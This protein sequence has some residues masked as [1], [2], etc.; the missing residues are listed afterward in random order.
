[1]CVSIER[2]TLIHR[3][4]HA[5]GELI[6]EALIAV[7]RRNRGREV[8]VDVRQRAGGHRHLPDVVLERRR[9][10]VLK[11]QLDGVPRF[12]RRREV[13]VELLQA[14]QMIIHDLRDRCAVR[15]DLATKS[16]QRLVGQAAVLAI[17]A[18]LFAGEAEKHANGDQ[19]DL[20]HHA[21]DRSRAAPTCGW[22]LGCGRGLADSR[23]LSRSIGWRVAHGAILSHAVR[24]WTT[25]AMSNSKS[26]VSADARIATL[27]SYAIAAPSPAD[28]GS[29][30][31]VTAPLASCTQ[32]LRVR[33]VA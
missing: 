3:L 29:P 15:E 19:R 2:R 13:R 18:P 9:L 27:S 24:G 20:Q 32:P 8:G 21:A 17:L 26:S 5:T 6:A 14:R 33:S 23:G 7:R 1:M 28:S 16:L 10:K 11:I 30:L 22:R 12:D 25:Q 31:T 4:N